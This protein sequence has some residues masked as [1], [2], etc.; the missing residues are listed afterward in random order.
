MDYTTLKIV[1]LTG[2]ALTFMG[3]SGILAIN[4]AGGAPFSKRLI[5]YIAQGVG[6]LLLIVTGFG[7]GAAL[8]LHAPPG[9]MKA[10]FVIWLLAGG[11]MVLATR[12]SRYGGAVLAIFTL[13]VVAA[14]WLAIDKPF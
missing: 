4:M 5:F 13:L 8:G 7:L 1:H 14:A 6:L 9:W 3:L 11:A 10:K 12:F 2:L